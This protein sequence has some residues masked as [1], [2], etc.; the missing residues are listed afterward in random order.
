MEDAMIINKS[1]FERGFGHA[2]V[3]KSEYIDLNNLKNTRVH[4]SPSS[5]L[6]FNNYI[7]DKDGKWYRPYP[8]LDEDGLPF[9]GCKLTKGGAY[10]CIY[11]QASQK[12]ELIKYKGT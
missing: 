2:S 7:K 6:I 1:A 4:I 12:H 11:D 8:E 5:L 10:Y 9:V 3:Y